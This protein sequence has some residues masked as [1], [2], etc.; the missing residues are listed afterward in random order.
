MKLTWS[1]RGISVADQSTSDAELVP[2]TLIWTKTSKRE[3]TYVNVSVTQANDMP[4][5]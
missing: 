5:E 1:K 3:V 4:L 2:K